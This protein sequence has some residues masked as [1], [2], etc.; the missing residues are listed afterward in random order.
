MTKDR[1]EQLVEWVKNGRIMDAMNE[2][3][4]HDIIMQ[5]N[6]QPPTTGLAANLAREQ[7]FVD[8]VAVVHACEAPVVL[9]D[10]DHAAI[11]WLLDYTNTA[12]V[13]LRLDQIALQTW[14][15]GKITTERFIYDSSNVVVEA[16]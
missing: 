9:V 15:D 5:D 2:F 16:A 12:G 3:Y 8:S 11:H 14:R 10:G 13:R 6:T 4:A 1:V 7:A